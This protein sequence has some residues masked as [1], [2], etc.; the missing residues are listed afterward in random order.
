LCTDNLFLIYTLFRAQE[1]VTSTIEVCSPDTNLLPTTE[2]LSLSDQPF[3]TLE[4]PE[5]ILDEYVCFVVCLSPLKY[6]VL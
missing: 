3:S 5:E 2:A 6:C 4:K 1:H